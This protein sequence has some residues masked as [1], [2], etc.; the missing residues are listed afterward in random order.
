MAREPTNAERLVYGADVKID[1]ETGAPI[2]T[3]IGALPPSEQPQIVAARA[4]IAAKRRAAELAAAQ[5]RIADDKA[6]LERDTAA[7]AALQTRN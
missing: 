7:A 3:G 1:E 4:A 6:A 2:E 5:Q